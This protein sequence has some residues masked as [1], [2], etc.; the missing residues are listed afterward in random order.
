MMLRE[1][2]WL[3]AHGFAA[4]FECRVKTRSMRPP[5]AATV[6]PLPDGAARVDLAAP[7]DAIAP[8]QA[9]VFYEAHGSRV[10][11]GGWIAPSPDSGRDTGVAA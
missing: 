2:N 8:G 10:L 6:T 9:C 11:G 4:P 7:E 5:V 1:V 3:A